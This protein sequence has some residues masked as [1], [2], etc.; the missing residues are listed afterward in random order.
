MKNDSKSLWPAVVDV[1][2][3]K[4]SKEK[5]LGIDFHNEIDAWSKMEFKSR[6]QV[7]QLKSNIALVRER[8][9]LNDLKSLFYSF[10]EKID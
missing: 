2:K 8:K 5:D 3:V 1:T 9:T 6:Q 7:K 4:Y 10:R